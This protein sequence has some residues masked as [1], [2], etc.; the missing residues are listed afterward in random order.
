MKR[1][2]IKAH[3]EVQEDDFIRWWRNEEA[4]FTIGLILFLCVFAVA[5]TIMAYLN[6]L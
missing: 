4:K 5:I 3:A 2:K 6:T 1:R